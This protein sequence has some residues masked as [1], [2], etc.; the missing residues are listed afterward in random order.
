MILFGKRWILISL[1]APKTIHTE[2]LQT[3]LQMTESKI[4]GGNLM[5]AI[6]YHN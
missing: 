4:S 1:K 5:Q 3:T 6:V 2:L